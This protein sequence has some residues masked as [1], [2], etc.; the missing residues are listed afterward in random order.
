MT[1]CFMHAPC[2]VVHR[3]AFTVPQ[4]LS[5]ID[6]STSLQQEHETLRG[7]TRTNEATSP[8]AAAD[9][10]RLAMTQARPRHFTAPL[11]S[12]RKHSRPAA[13][14]D[15]TGAVTAQRPYFQHCGRV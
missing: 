11:G 5:R 12:S 2:Y 3:L 1:A 4:R 15:H 10:P 14:P 6:G 13:A 7:W 9:A 8:W